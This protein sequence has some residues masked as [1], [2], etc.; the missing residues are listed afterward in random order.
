MPVQYAPTFS[1]L[2]TLLADHGVWLECAV[3]VIV[4]QLR[5]LEDAAVAVV[6]LVAALPV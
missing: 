6:I 3:G 5:R 1:H 4:D 2:A